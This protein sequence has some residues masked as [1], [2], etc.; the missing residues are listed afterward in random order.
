MKITMKNK[1][2]FR[3]IRHLRFLCVI[4]LIFCTALNVFAQITINVKNK[5]IREIIKTIE[6]TTDYKFF[7]NDDFSALNTVTTLNVK[8]VSIDNVLKTLFSGSGISWEKKETNLV[9]LTPVE[10]IAP[11]TPAP[12]NKGQTHKVTGTVTDDKGETLIGVYV[13]VS[14]TKEGTVT[15]VNGNFSITVHSSNAVLN[16]SYLG[17]GSEDIAVNGQNSIKVKLL[18]EARSMNEVVVTALGIKQDYKALSYDVQTV[19]AK[20]LNVSDASFVNSLAGKVAGV[21]INSSST[22]VG[23]SD[24]VVMRGTKSLAGNNNA[25]Y[26]VDGIPLPSLQSNQPA[27]IFSGAGQTGEGISDFNSDDIESVSILSGGAA[28]ALYGS[29]A[30]NGVI[31]ITTK[32]GQNNGLAINVSNSTTFNSPFVMPKFQNTYGLSG[33]GS[34]YSWGDKLT[35]PS[36]YSPKDFFQTGYNV[37]NSIS[38][39]TG[40]PKNQTYFSA[41]SDN[42]EGIIHNNNYYRYNFTFRNTSQLLKDDKLTLDL[43]ANYMSVREQN[44]LAQGQ[45]FNPLIPIYL[46]PPGDDIT[47]YQDFE[48]YN[49]T[50]NFKTQYWPFGDLGFQMQNPYWETERDMFVNNKNRYLI[51]AAL[52]YNINNWM[53]ITARAKL[54]MDN[55]GDNKEYDASTSGLFA[56]AEGGYYTYHISNQQSYADVLLNIN[57]NIKNFSIDAHIG[58]SILDDVYN[59]STIGGNLESTPNLFT[60]ENLSTSTLQIDQEGYHDQTQSVF[61]TA[62]LGYKSM[63]FVDGTVRNDWVSALTNTEAKSIIYPSFGLSGILTDLLKIQSKS[64]SFLKARV[65]YSE[66]GNAPERFISTTTYPMVNGYPQLTSYLPATNLQ[67]ERT[68][69]FEAGLN[70]VFFGNK[71]KLDATVYKS[72]TY[73]QLF[74]PTLSASSGYSSFYV[75]AGRID[76]QGIELAL[77]LNQK[78]GPVDWT[79]N[80][81]YSLNQNKIVE[82]LNSYKAPDGENVSLDSLNMGGT[83]SYENILKKGGSMNDIYVSTLMVDEHGEIIVNSTNRTVTPNQNNYI[84]AG[85]TDPNYTLGF[86]N[87]FSYKGFDLSFLI[88]ARVGGVGVSV[89][90]AIMDAFGVSEASAVARDNGGAT[91]NGYL[92]PAQAYYQTVGGGTSGIGSCYVY[93][94][95]NVRLA[96]LSLGY[97]I[98]I[99]DVKGVKGVTVSL[100]G[101]NLFMFYNKAPFDPESTANTGTYFQ[102][103]DYF[104]QPSL[105][106]LGFAVKFMF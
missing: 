88:N 12:N 103:V 58:T 11:E 57:K 41:G 18:P 42:S 104:M 29:E 47:K 97:E 5:P 72:S 20:E 13:L 9:V 66:V 26:V 99:K 1:L 32:K 21:T 67:P 65:S 105:R 56:T 68:K 2:N 10:V 80:L 33:V 28:A 24:R 34:Y 3:K 48:R 36:S 55:E 81:V 23:G 77:S 89:T 35:T 63:I 76:N 50:R 16:F 102:G 22:G 40:T 61:A 54:D 49:V 70:A 52:K 106:S 79:S 90:Q 87:T 96:E 100:V 43:S 46:F 91:V 44:M 15:D 8:N 60:L 82:L 31:L 45:Y 38:I 71:L 59:Y 25:L 6:K 93:S 4:A 74:N 69:S 83:G 27:D 51:S 7:Y 17:Y 98:P 95:T 101:K 39:S 75:N 86:R 19:N 30:A 37:N 64:L 78:L 84:L 53:N 62:E 14:G 94:A 85:H 92:I 73:N